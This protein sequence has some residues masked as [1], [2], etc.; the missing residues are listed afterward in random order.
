MGKIRVEQT[1]PGRL[2]LGREIA[3]GDVPG[4]EQGRKGL[5]GVRRAVPDGTCHPAARIMRRARDR[6]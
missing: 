4:R 3:R 5:E 6:R 2:K 1:Q